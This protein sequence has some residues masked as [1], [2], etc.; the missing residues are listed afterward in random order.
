MSDHIVIND[1]RFNSLIIPDAPLEKIHN[2]FLWAEGPV[3]FPHGDYYLWSD[4]PNNLVMQ[5]TEGAGARLYD[6]NSN[7]C[8]GH[9]RDLEGRLVTCEHLTRRVTRTE[10]DGSLTVIADS[11][12]GKRLNSPND[13]VV[14]SDGSIWFT[15]PPYGIISDYEGQIA[16]QE[17]SGCYVFRVDPV[18]FETKIVVDDFVKPNGLAFSADESVLYVADSA[19]SHD[20]DGPHHIRAFDCDGERLSGGDVLIDIEKGV[21]DG[22]R[23]D[24]DGNIWTSSAIGVECFDRHGVALGAILVPEVAA[25]LTFGGRSGSQMMITATTSVYTIDVAARGVT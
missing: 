10:H 15:D 17:Q 19:R 5:W 7:Y 24:T 6:T 21:P 12:N 18:T 2:G 4:I 14:K 1:P 20:P 11:H 9:T 23:V 25:N 3:Y 16:P 8:N 22:M 13:V